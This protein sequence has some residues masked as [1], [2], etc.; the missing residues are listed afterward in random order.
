VFIL[1]AVTTRFEIFPYGLFKDAFIAAEAVFAKPETTNRYELYLGAREFDIEDVDS[2]PLRWSE[3]GVIT[4]DE[5]LAFNGYTLYTPVRS[6]FPIR[7]VDMQ[8][9]TAW[10]WNINWGAFGDERLDGLP[11]SMGPGLAKQRGIGV[12]E[13]TVFANGDLLVVLN[14]AWYTPWGLALIKVDKNGDPIWSYTRQVHHEISVADDGRIYALSH[15][16]VRDPWPDLE[17][18]VTPFVDDLV[19]ILSPDGDELASVSILEAI[20]NSPYASL[21][22]Y[23]DPADPK[24]DLLHVNSIQVLDAV[25]AQLLPNARPG[26]VLV[27]MRNADVLAVVDVEDVTVRWAV[28]G[29]WKLQHDADLL[30]NGNLLLFDN[31]GDVENGG[32]SRVIEFDPQSLE[33]VW[34]YPGPD[35][36]RLY[37]SFLGSQSRL[38]N[39]NTLIAESN[40]GRIIE[41]TQNRDIV[42]EYRVPELVTKP[43]GRKLATAQFATRYVLEDLPFLNETQ[44]TE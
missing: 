11:L 42:W 25:S 38:P 4:H 2:P 39:G 44:I 37:S 15:V 1:G 24:G 3:P 17:H 21:L 32:T 41:V 30:A 36:P 18:I 8:G 34:D 40:N 29:T 35:Q 26:N 20:Q 19:V 6:D 28:R 14:T 22:M 5:A 7:L 31:R 43:D 23:A 16:L 10:Q 12:G 33:I 13:P 9:N 27:S